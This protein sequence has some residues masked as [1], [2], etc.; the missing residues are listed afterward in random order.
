MVRNGDIP[1]EFWANQQLPLTYLVSFEPISCLSHTWW[2]LSQSAASHIPG[3][4]WANQLPLTYLVSF[5][6]ISCCLSHTW[7]VL[8]QSA[9]SRPVAAPPCT[10]RGCCGWRARADE[11]D[12]WGS[13]RGCPVGRPSRRGCP[14]YED[15]QDGG[16]TSRHVSRTS[17][18]Q[19]AALQNSESFY[20]TK[21]E[22]GAVSDL[23]TPQKKRIR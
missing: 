12:C 19:V 6:P 23:C 7:W 15:L 13:E 9:A 3:V 2:V 22:R 4:F 21:F 16:D 8:S 17:H 18:H 10:S 20:R 14:K 5:E 11:A 1:H